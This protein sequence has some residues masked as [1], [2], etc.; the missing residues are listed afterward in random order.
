MCLRGC[1]G[2]GRAEDTGNVAL[3][4]DGVEGASTWEGSCPFPSANS[5]ADSIEPRAF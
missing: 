1:A 5:R 2:V 3:T 4:A